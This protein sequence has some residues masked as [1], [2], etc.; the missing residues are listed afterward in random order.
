MQEVLK[1]GKNQHLIN[2]FGRKMSRGGIITLF[3]ALK[4]YQQPI[5][6]GQKTVGFAQMKFYSYL[7]IE[8][9]IQ[10]TRK[11]NFSID[12]ITRFYKS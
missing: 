2:T 9:I 5:V 12:V 8:T 1:L 11:V 4:S 10:L 3:G 6:L 7:K